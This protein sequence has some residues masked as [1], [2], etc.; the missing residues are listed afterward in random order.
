MFFQKKMVYRAKSFVAQMMKMAYV[1]QSQP[2]PP[3][4]GGLGGVVIGQGLRR[5]RRG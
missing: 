2:P 5:E 3:S 1:D 4:Q